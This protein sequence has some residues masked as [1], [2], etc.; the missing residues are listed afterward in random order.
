MDKPHIIMLFVIALLMLALGVILGLTIGNNSNTTKLMDIVQLQEYLNERIAED[1]WIAP[2]LLEVDGKVGPKTIAA[3]E[4]AAA[5][6]YE[7]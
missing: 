3:W 7:L 6:E 4:R 2:E 1:P 5:M